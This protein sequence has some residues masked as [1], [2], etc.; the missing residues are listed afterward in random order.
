MNRRTL[1]NVLL[2]IS[3]LLLL[4]C[5]LAFWLAA[6]QSGTRWLLGRA[7]PLLPPELRIGEVSGTLLDGI[8]ISGAAW[9]GEA[10]RVN[11]RRVTTAIELLQKGD[12]L[13][14]QEPWKSMENTGKW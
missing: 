11:V 5:C 1:R 4:I 6:T 3:A 10:Q 2:V 7:A 9:A 12:S 14:A 8:T 13:P